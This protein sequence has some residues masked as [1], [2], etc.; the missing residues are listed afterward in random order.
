M[1]VAPPPVT[2]S[3]PPARDAAPRWA[4]LPLGTLPG[5]AGGEK[6]GERSDWVP[7]S[8][9]PWRERLGSK[10]C[11]KASK[12][13]ENA[14]KLQLHYRHCKSIT[15]PQASDREW[16]MTM[17]ACKALRLGT[18]V[19]LSA[20][21][22]KIGECFKGHAWPIHRNLQ[23]VATKLVGQKMASR[24]IELFWLRHLFGANRFNTLLPNSPEHASMKRCQPALS[25]RLCH[26][27]SSLTWLLWPT[28][29]SLLPRG[30][31][32]GNTVRV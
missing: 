10:I 7:R 23:R 16:S 9:S 8:G 2:L 6:T 26:D 13:A 31:F 11:L 17:S 12:A 18:A 20:S 32:L 1:R 3:R 21:R 15:L 29:E 28:F 5:G 4:M 22:T 19:I 25:R 14:V 30:F 24:H 27:E